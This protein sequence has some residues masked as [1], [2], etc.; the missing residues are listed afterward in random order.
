MV[1]NKKIVFA[2]YPAIAEVSTPANPTEIPVAGKHIQVVEDFIDLDADLPEGDIL[3][4]TLE[5][6]IDPWMVSRFREPSV[7]SYSPPL[8]LNETITD[9]TVS[10]VL[11]SNNV[12]YK[13]GDIVYGRNGFGYMQEYVQIGADYAKDFYVVRNDPK[14]QGV[15]LAHYVG[16]L[17]MSGI[18]AYYG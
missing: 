4:K 3:L 11:K 15:S 18:T 12:N 16:A 10:V 2:E 1:S 14:D 13:V 8:P 9:D 6:S 17:G 5:I 7:E